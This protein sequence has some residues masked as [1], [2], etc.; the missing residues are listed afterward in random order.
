MRCRYCGYEIPEGELYCTRCGEE[1]FIVPDYNPLDDMLTAQIKVGVNNEGDT[2]YLNHNL[3][4]DVRGRTSVRRTGNPQNAA[5]RR[6]TGSGRR[7]TGPG[8][9]MDPRRQ[10]APGRSTGS[11]RSMGSGRSTGTG[12]NPAPGRNTGTGRNSA[13]GRDMGTGRIPGARGNTGTGRTPGSRGNTA[14]GRNSSSRRN[15]GTGRNTGYMR[16]NGTRQNTAGRELSERERYR[17]QMEKKRES[18][19]KKRRNITI[20]LVILVLA[21]GAGC[22]TLYQNSY[23]GI[24]NKGYQAI[25]NQEYSSAESFFNQAIGKN[26]KKSEAYVGLSQVYIRQDRVDDAADL[27]NDTIA[28]QPDNADIYEAYMEFCVNNDRKT[29]IPL[30]LDEA[31]DSIRKKLSDYIIAVPEFNLDDEEVY[32]DVQQLELSAGKNTIQ[33]TTDQTDPLQSGKSYDGPIQLEEGE[34]VIRAVALDKRGIP[35]MSVEKTYVIEF[36]VEDAPAVSPSTGQYESAHLIEIKVPDGYEAYYTMDGE[37][38]T[39]ASTKYSGPVDMPE[40]ETLFKAIL[41][42]G[43]GRVSGI[44]TR[45]YMLEK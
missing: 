28:K 2:D 3:S 32:D 37:D 45:N 17:R 29:L 36:P 31:Q 35:G 22:Y 20:V 19:K 12:R 4:D 9:S 40:G 18:L 38:P 34:N 43:G 21:I 10:T 11:G 41:V 33:Y 7:N 44:T 23:D 25:K 15:T 13:S 26:D 27:F 24:V 42:S 30:V 5:A 14:A 16:N 6:N 1:V 39:T 8:R